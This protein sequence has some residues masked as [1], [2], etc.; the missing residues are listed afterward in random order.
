[1]AELV[2]R[3]GSGWHGDGLSGDSDE[4]KDPVANDSHLLHNE[5]AV[6]NEADAYVET[7]TLSLE[8]SALQ[9]MYRIIVQTLSCTLLFIN[10]A[11]ALFRFTWLCRVIPCHYTFIIH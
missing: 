9:L 3:A 11:V 6:N 5:C 10:T 1:M 7:K 2:R 8:P 4:E